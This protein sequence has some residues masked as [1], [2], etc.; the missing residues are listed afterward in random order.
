[1][2]L[3]RIAWKIGVLEENLFSATLRGVQEISASWEAYN[4][5][6]RFYCVERVI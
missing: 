2:R 4:R 3:G 1:M 6:R 5:S